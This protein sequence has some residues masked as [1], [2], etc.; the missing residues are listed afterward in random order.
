MSHL[1]KHCRSYRSPS[2]QEVDPLAG[3]GEYVVTA[4]DD[5][6]VRLFNYPCVIEEAPCRSVD[7]EKGLR[8]NLILSPAREEMRI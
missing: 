1:S 5:G 2:F 7:G 6:K 4:S 8:I 3:D